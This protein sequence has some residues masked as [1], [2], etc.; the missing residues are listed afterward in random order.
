MG[1]IYHM[2][3]E[4]LTYISREVKALITKAI[5]EHREKSVL[6]HPDGSVTEAKLNTAVRTKLNKAITANVSVDGGT[7]TPSVKVTESETDDKKVFNFAFSGLKG[8]KGDKGAQGDRG[9]QGLQGAAGAAGAAATI[10]IGTVTTGAA[11]TN[12]SVTNAGTANAAK[13]NFTIPRGA[14]GAKGDKGE[15][16]AVG[17]TPTIAVAQGSHINAVGT[18]SVSVSKSG[19]T[20]TF[21]FDYLKGAKGDKGD[22]GVNATITA[23]GTATKAGLTK[24]YTGT[25]SDTDGTMTQSAITSQLNGKAASSHTHNNYLPLSGGTVYGNILLDCAKDEEDLAIQTNLD[26]Y[27]M[28]GEEDVHFYNAHVNYIFAYKVLSVGEDKVIGNANISP[29]QITGIYSGTAAVAASSAL[30]T[31]C[32]YMKYS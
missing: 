3:K 13:L 19:T 32:I 26:N 22:A 8:E 24:L 10:T 23:V 18:P 30:P 25:G 15:T 17:A 9:A 2:T 31:G 21:T 27:G 28:L 7:G 5:K 14:T 6:D 16:G 4:S 12:A 20:S 11:G 1:K 29:L